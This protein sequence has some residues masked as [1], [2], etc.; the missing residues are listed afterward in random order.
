MAGL[1]LAYLHLI[2]P[3]QAQGEHPNLDLSAHFFRPLY[4]GTLIVAGGY[5]F[6]RAA[7]VLR[8]G[9]ANLVAFGQLYLANPDLPERFRLRTALN[10]PDKATFYGGGAAGYTDYPTLAQSPA[11]EPPIE[12]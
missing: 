5:T 3:V 6:E 10:V 2:E 11:A 8:S 7:A 1:D 12:I 4:P 9:E